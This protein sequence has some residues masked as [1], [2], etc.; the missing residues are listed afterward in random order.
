MPSDEPETEVDF[1]SWCRDEFEYPDISDEGS[2]VVLEGDRP[3]RSPSSPS[4]TSG[5]SA[6]TR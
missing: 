3:V 1:E 4:I 6:T 5:A 2:F